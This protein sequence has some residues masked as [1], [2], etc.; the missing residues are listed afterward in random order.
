MMLFMSKKFKKLFINK[1]LTLVARVIRFL[2]FYEILVLK[3]CKILETNWF[4]PK[5]SFLSRF[6]NIIFFKEYYHRSLTDR[7][8]I[9]SKLM[10]E[11]EGAK[12]ALHYDENRKQYPPKDEKIGKL[13][14]KQAVLGFDQ[15]SNLLAEDSKNFC[16]IQLGA[17]SGKEISY[18][19]LQFPDAEFIYT[20]IFEKTK[21]FAKSKLNLPNI[22]YVTCSSES[23]P[24][25][26]EVNKKDKIL[27]YSS[28]SAQYVFPEYLDKTFK[29]LKNIENK[30]IYIIFD[31]PGTD[32]FVNPKKLKGSYP[33]GNFSY[34][35]NYKYYAE[36]NGF[37][38]IEWNL[39]KP[40]EGKP[41]VYLNGVFYFKD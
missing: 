15:I 21:R 3:Y 6:I 29:L 2:P 19:A 5:K 8:R 37:E 12:W 4:K 18:F 39:I 24:A 16:F 32:F 20:D 36:E 7:M 33:R 22:K 1:I 31:E 40:F 9:L 11:D 14:W 34:T 26:A 28:G 13:P 27:I 23:I 41:L 10:G 38:T 30:H 35:H 17:S 25:L